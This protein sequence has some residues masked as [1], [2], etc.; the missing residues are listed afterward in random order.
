MM[1]TAGGEGERETYIDVSDLN[2]F[3][4]LNIAYKVIAD[5]RFVKD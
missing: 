4:R 5:Y 2:V 3:Q 1:S